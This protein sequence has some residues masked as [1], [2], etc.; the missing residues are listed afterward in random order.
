M[1][2][3]WVAPLIAS[4][5]L[6]GC[7]SNRQSEA[8]MESGTAPAAAERDEAATAPAEGDAGKVTVEEIAATGAATAYEVVVRLHRDWL[9][10]KLTGAAVSVYQDNQRIGG[11]ESLRRLQVQ[12]IAELQYLDGRSAVMR[13]GPDVGGG[14]IIVIRN[15]T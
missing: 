14:V 13:W 4:M 10:D 3:T 15:R 11:E 1:S 7:A 5:V 12:D 8:G 9:R 6:A 2:R